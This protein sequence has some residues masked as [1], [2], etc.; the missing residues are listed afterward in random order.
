MD[1]SISDEL[2]KRIQWKVYAGIYPCADDVVEHAL[3][4]LDQRDVAVEM[5]RD[6]VQ[7]GIDDIENGRYKTYSA[8]SRDELLE[9]IKKRAQRLD[10]ERKSRRSSR[11]KVI[12]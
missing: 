3:D 12:F 7:E 5:V 2:L 6:L 1:N 9:D 4:L 10:S 8:E 11:L